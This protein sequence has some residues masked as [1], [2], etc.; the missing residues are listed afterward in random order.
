[1]DMD[2]QDLQDEGQL[3]LPFGEIAWE[4]IGCAFKLI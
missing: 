2:K 4:I 1:M 3:D